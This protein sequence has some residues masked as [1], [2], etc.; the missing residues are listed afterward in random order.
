MGAQAAHGA[1]VNATFTGVSPGGTASITP[2]GNVGA[3]VY[4]FNYNHGDLNW[5]APSFGAFCIEIQ[6]PI[7]G[8]QTV[9][10]DVAPIEDAPSSFADGMGVIRADR[11][12]ELFGRRYAES[13]DSA[14][15][16]VAFGIAVWEI[17]NDDTFDLN[18]GGFIANSTNPAGAK[19][20]AASWL[21]EIDGNGPRASLLALLSDTAQDYVVVNTEI[22][23]PGAL[24]LASLGLAS[25]A[26][27]RR[28]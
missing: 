22:P 7:S 4:T 3:G 28:R 1:I 6:Q 15:N 16:A 10:F 12:K 23:A 24:A 5:L 17:V 9:T 25:G 2:G 27:R 14:E 13:S 8:G 19:D 20:L 11:L 26:R 21:A 18:T